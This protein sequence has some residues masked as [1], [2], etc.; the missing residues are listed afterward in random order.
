VD[1]KELDKVS[2]IVRGENGAY[3]TTR[4]GNTAFQGEFVMIAA[5]SPPAIV[6]ERDE[7]FTVAARANQAA[8]ELKR[9]R[10][11]NGAATAATDADEQKL[12]ACRDD[13][14]RRLGVFLQGEYSIENC[15]RR[16]CAAQVAS[17]SGAI[18]G[19]IDR[20]RELFDQHL[21]ILESIHGQPAFRSLAELGFAVPD[22][23]GVHRA[24]ETTQEIRNQ[25]LERW[26][27]TEREFAYA[28]PVDVEEVV[29]IPPTA[30]LRSMVTIVWNVFRHPFSTTYVDLSTGESVT[31]GDDAE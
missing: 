8:A 13:L 31:F 6:T 30:F 16:I 4:K 11:E 28:F 27:L 23:A 26:P 22:F 3:N 1:T 18:D 12:A 15:W 10:M 24:I 21:A 29:Y 9:L 7:L 19:E 20:V 5:D 25:V 17:N 14:N 2:M